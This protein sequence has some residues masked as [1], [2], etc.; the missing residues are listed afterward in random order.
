MLVCSRLIP[1]DRLSSAERF[2][3]KSTFTEGCNV[4]GIREDSKVY[5]RLVARTNCMGP[6]GVMFNASDRAAACK[7]M[8][9]FSSNVK[10]ARVTDV[11]K[12]KAV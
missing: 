4:G 1:T 3:T 7:Y 10:C 5:R 2:R 9:T 12:A 11:L 8:N 6:K